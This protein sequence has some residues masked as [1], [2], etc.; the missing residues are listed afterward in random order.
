M[1]RQ[2]SEIENFLKAIEEGFKGL[3]PKTFWPLNGGQVDSYFDVD[4]ALDIYFR[5]NKLKEKL[6]VEEIADLMPQADIIRIFLIHNAIVGLKVAKKIN[7]G[8]ISIED[9]V[10]FTL[11]LFEILKYKVKNDIFCLDGKNL[12]SSEEEILELLDKTNW[13]EPFSDEERKKIAFLITMANNICYTLYY[14]LFMTGGF[15]IHGPYDASKEF[16][17][18]AILL[19]RDYHDLNPKEL[20]PDL[21]MPY[22]R[23]RICTVY[24][25]LKLGVNFVNHPITQDSI[26]DKLI[27]YKLYLDDKEIT[28]NEVGGL[29]GL[30]DNISKQQTKKINALSNLDKVRKGAEIAFY[31][32]RK[33]RE[34]TGDDWRPPKEIE[35]TIER[36]GEEFIKKFQYEKIPSVEHWKRLFDPRD[37]YLGE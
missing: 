5:L 28:L 34:Y 9:R 32:F 23:I 19:I 15:Y 2:D 27:A 21:N 33:L 12:I 4:E 20:W 7:V 8:N 37:D 3:N 11:F 26:G 16:G 30:L 36:F 1:E 10:K 18:G 29:I 24:K 25:N 31:L 35:K 14:D 22:Q 6:S 17:E 13:D